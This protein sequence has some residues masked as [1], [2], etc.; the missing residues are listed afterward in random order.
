M[1][2]LPF[3]LT[4][5]VLSLGA[6]KQQTETSVPA[7]A[8][9]EAPA[10]PQKLTSSDNKITVNLQNGGFTDARNNAAVQPEGVTPEELTLLQRDE[11]RNI[12]LYAANLGKAKTA[13][14]AEYFAKLKSTLETDKNFD[15]V[16]VGAA[17]ENRMN[18]RFT[19]NNP[20]SDL[21][22]ENCIAIFEAGNIY[23][24]C[25]SSDTATQ[26]ELAAVLTEVAVAK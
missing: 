14:A 2:L 13:D 20:D 9:A 23:N 24:V 26:D 15:N 12:T 10:Q 25:A 6:C 22:S 17:T 7:G 5:A 3:V 21:L 1:K 11:A 8:S 4:A 18:Y 16:Q 19:Q